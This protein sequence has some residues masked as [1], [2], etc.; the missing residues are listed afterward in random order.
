MISYTNNRVLYEGKAKIVYAS[1]DSATVVSF[2][3]D[4]MTGF[5]GGKYAEIPTKGVVNNTISAH[6]FQVLEGFGIKTHFLYKIDDR[7]QCVKFCKMF[8][9]EVILRN[10]YAEHSSS[11]AKRFKL[12]PRSKLPGVVVEYFLKDDSACDPL[13]ST[14]HVLQ[15]GLATEEQLATI[16]RLAL[17]I[18]DILSAYLLARNLILAD[19]KL[20]FGISLEGDIVL[21]DEITPDTCR[22]WDLNTKQSYDKDV[23]RFETDNHDMIL[24]AYII[25]LHRIVS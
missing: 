10:Y 5:N 18:N 2:F 23:F 16:R 20:E 12:A 19:F 11:F 15:F 14:D 24:D 7:A 8:L 22:L 13:M 1:D 6:L 9:I 4:S 21:A 25:A 3:K 17:R